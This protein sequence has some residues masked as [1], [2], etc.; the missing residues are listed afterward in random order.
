MVLGETI[1]TAVE[2]NAST[3]GHK[4]AYIYEGETYSWAAL[5]HDVEACACS[6][7]G[8]GVRRKSRVGIW[9]LN[10]YE[11]VVCF[12]ACCQIGACPVLANYSYKR[13]EMFYFIDYAELEFLLVGD[14]KDG[15]D[16]LSLIHI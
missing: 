11:W 1:W 8:K 14:V 15:V 16:A 7:M 2:R 13:D 6:L 12:F 5:K 4:P 9:G 10:S 3:L